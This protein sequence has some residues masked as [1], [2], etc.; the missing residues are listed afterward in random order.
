MATELEVRPIVRTGAPPRTLYRWC[1][2]ACV[3]S[4]FGLLILV[5]A[6]ALLRG[7]CEEDSARSWQ[8]WSLP[9]PFEPSP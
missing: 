3:L 9:M 4:W 2:I 1:L 7:H 5:P 8:P 6:A